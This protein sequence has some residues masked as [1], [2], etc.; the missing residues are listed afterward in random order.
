MILCPPWIPAACLFLAAVSA[1]AGTEFDLVLE[2]ND[3]CQQR[4][5]DDPAC[6]VSAL[7]RGVIKKHGVIDPE[8]GTGDSSDEPDAR[9]YSGINIEELGSDELRILLREAQNALD[10]R[11]AKEALGSADCHTTQPGEMCHTEVVWAK[12]IGIHSHPDWYPGLGPFSSA[13]EFQ[14]HLHNQGTKGCLAPCRTPMGNTHE[15]I[16]PVRASGSRGMCSNG[17]PFTGGTR[18]SRCFCQLARNPGCANE[19]CACPQGCGNDVAWRSAETV[20]F[21]NRA[22]AEGCNPSTVLLTSHKNYFSTPGEL[23][24]CGQD[25]LRIIETLLRDSWNIYQ[26]HVARGSMHQCFHGSQTASVKYLHLQSFCSYASFHAMPN[27]NPAVG[28]CVV[29]EDLGQ[30][31]SLAK[32]LFQMMQ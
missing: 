21:K 26:T 2:L 7:Q 20:T 16:G 5:P 6:E 8:F 23:K 12:S 1:A 3:E 31:P 11:S 9:R 24:K 25:A 22:R 29:M 10:L 19:P 32:Q 4:Q 30:V 15:H 14:A 27:K 28:S 18:A 13:E 17:R